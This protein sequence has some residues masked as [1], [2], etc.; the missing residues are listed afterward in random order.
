MSKE[1]TLITIGVVVVLSPFLGL[2]HSW[3]AWI[4]PL[5][6]LAVLLVGYFIRKEHVASVAVVQNEAPVI[7]APVYDAPS[8]IA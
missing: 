8:P 1:G 7:S 3:L 4:L 2:P 6:G 5:C